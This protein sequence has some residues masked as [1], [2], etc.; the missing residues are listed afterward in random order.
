MTCLGQ[1]SVQLTW[2]VREICQFWKNAFL[3]AA[4]FDIHTIPYFG[5][6]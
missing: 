5:V 2:T 6:R 3:S 1:P 4:G